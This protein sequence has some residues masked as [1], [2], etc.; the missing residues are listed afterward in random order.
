MGS[1]TFGTSYLVHSGSFLQ[2]LLPVFSLLGFGFCE[3]WERA[4]RN[5]AQLLIQVQ[6]YLLNIKKEETESRKQQS[7]Q[8]LWKTQELQ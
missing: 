8:K 2:E 7:K 3:L 4:L 6:W 5:Q 1:I